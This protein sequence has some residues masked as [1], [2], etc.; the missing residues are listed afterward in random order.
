VVYL[1]VLLSMGGVD[2]HRVLSK[3]QPQLVFFIALRYMVS[4]VTIAGLGLRKRAGDDPMI[5]MTFLSIF[6][7][8]M[9]ADSA[10][11]WY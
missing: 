8:N 6:V 4:C 3:G 2:I 5:G 11:F 10:L 1:L 9:L 7:I